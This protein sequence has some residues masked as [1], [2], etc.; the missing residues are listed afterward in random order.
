[1]PEALCQLFGNGYR[2]MPA[3]GAA[4]A[5]GEVGLAF[6]GVAGYEEGE[7]SACPLEEFPAVF[8]AEDRLSDGFVVACERPEVGIVVGVGKE[9]DVEERVHVEGGAVLEAEGDEADGHL[10]G[11]RFREPLEPQAGV[12]RGVARGI[13]DEICHLPH[14]CEIPPLKAYGL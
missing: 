3:A 12:E 14:V 4:D 1:M 2:A 8:R 6:C 13:D 9:A 10:A 11:E 7:Q 5:D